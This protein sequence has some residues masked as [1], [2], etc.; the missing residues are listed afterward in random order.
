MVEV[1]ETIVVQSSIKLVYIFFI[2]ILNN[3]VISFSLD[4]V[5]FLINLSLVITSPA[6]KLVDN[7]RV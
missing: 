7:L 3:Y 2:H 1:H 5:I 6:S 4:I